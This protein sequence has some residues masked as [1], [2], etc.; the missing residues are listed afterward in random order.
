MLEGKLGR[1]LRTRHSNQARSL[2]DVSHH[3][4]SRQGQVITRSRCQGY[5]G[6]TSGVSGSGASVGRLEAWI[7]GFPWTGARADARR[8]RVS[9]RG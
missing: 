9:L 5:K 1:K 7:I 6:L 3:V 4:K 2:D 8:V